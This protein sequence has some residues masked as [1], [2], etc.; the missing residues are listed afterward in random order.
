MMVQEGRSLLSALSFLYL[1]RRG[2]YRK[3][4][5]TAAELQTWE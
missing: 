1:V 3:L 5:G 4:M 2:P